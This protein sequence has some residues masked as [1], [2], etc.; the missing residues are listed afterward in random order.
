[1]FEYD[2]DYADFEDGL[3]YWLLHH[4]RL[5]NCRAK[6]MV[7]DQEDV[8]RYEEDMSADEYGLLASVRRSKTEI[9]TPLTL[10]AFHFLFPDF[11]VV[12][13]SC[14]ISNSRSLS[15]EKLVARFDRTRLVREYDTALE[16][17]QGLRENLKERRGDDRPLALV[18][19][20]NR[21]KMSDSFVVHNAMPVSVDVPGKHD[22]WTRDDGKKLVLETLSVFME[23]VDIRHNPDSWQASAIMDGWGTP[24]RGDRR[25]VVGS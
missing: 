24:V 8:F 5:E 23:G 6:W 7:R 15:A 20:W 14:C 2:S 17:E 13:D 1:M 21:L 22:I 3:V 19:H 9:R 25:E 16:N 11:P 4:Y 18:F 10:R 12:L